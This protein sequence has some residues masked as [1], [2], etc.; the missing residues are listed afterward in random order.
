MIAYYTLLERKLMGSVQ[1]RT[2]PK[3]VG[4]WGVLQPISDGLK[5]L[6]KEI[7]MPRYANVFIFMFAPMLAFIVALSVWSVIPF[8][9]GTVVSGITQSLFFIFAVSSIGVYGILLGG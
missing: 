1:R 4:Y 9:D 2:G 8:F 6:L 7:T 3:F 5:L